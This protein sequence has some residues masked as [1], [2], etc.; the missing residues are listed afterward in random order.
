MP[1]SPKARVLLVVLVLGGIVVALS[2]LPRKVAAPTGDNH[3]E[4]LKTRET[5]AQK[6]KQDSD[7]DGL[8]DWEE[9]IFKTDPHNADTDGDGAPDGEEVASNRDP[10]LKGPN[11][12]LAALAA[13]AATSTRALPRN[14]TRDLAE[15]FGEQ[16]VVPRLVRPGTPID[17]DAFSAALAEEISSVPF[18]TAPRI[19]YQELVIAKDTSPAA[20]ASYQKTVDRIVAPFARWSN[21]P[22]ILVFSEAMR[23]EDFSRLTALD[24]YLKTYEQVIPKLK[25]VAVPPALALLHL[26]YVNAGIRQHEAV[27]LM[28]NAEE[29]IV[30]AVA[31]AQEYVRTAQEFTTVVRKLQEEYKKAGVTAR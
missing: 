21:T 28:R 23:D 14:L 18:T 1:N 7:N 11:D 17:L 31:G 22:A 16:F 9:T 4:T 13:P 5:Q 24:P 10:L 6:L 15:K 25:K 3:T 29:D 27:K 20:V 8:R 26:D 12:A 30:G 19:K 2:F